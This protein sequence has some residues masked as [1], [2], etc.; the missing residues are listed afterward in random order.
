MTQES[1][2]N[3]EHKARMQEQQQEVR[4]AV[5][6]ATEE[7]GIIVYLY[8]QG[9]GKSSSALGTLLRALGHGQRAGVLQF[10]K[11]KWKTGEQN[12]LQAS[13]QV[14]YHVM[15]SG[16]T[17]DTQDREKDI[18]AAQKAWQVAEQL[19]QDQ[20]YNF[21]LLDEITYMYDFNY[22]PLE[23]A[24]QALKNRPKDQN[25]FI[26]GRSAIPAL[27]EL[28]DTVSEVRDIKHAFRAGVKAQR[29]IEW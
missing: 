5:K 8:G 11:G 16:F 17:W 20:Q 27:V 13:P 22:L 21:I 6:A 25:V 3:A 4:K 9:K 29:G 7:R 19:L 23:P 15:G 24:L 10:I 14:D 12:F 26:T 1:D 18:A 28:A 2:I